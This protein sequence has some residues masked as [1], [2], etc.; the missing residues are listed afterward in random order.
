MKRPIFA[1]LGTIL[2]V[3]VLP[4]G[5][6]AAGY[7]AQSAPD[8][9]RPFRAGLSNSKNRPLTAR[10]LQKLLD[11]LRLRTGL[12]DMGF[13]EDGFLILGDRTRIVSGSATARA[14]IF[15]T[16]DGRD[17]FRLEN[18]DHSPTVAFAQ[19]RATADYEDAARVRHTVFDVEFDFH[20]FSELRGPAEA[21]SAFD[22]TMV[23]LHELGHGVLGLRDTIS[24]NDPVGP[25]ERHINRIRRELNLPERLSYNAR[26]TR[27]TMPGK[28]PECLRADIVYARAESGARDSRRK[29]FY[30]SFN[31][32]KVSVTN[33]DESRSLGGIAYRMP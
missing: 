29:L 25:C 3:A 21:L 1:L 18:H 6:R 4:P 7:Q 13:D 26:A 16:V 33:D 27:T 15:A 31:A 17:C 12:M 30:M 19:M 23:L 14:L 32:E 10:Q 22:M 28:T 11:G 8:A 20:D 9:V 24:E 5:T 2:C